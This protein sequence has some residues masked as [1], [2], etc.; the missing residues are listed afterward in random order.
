MT[1]VFCH[2]RSRE[3]RV[4]TDTL[5]IAFDEDGDLLDGMPI[6]YSRA[7]AIVRAHRVSMWE[8][9]VTLA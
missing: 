5:L 1:V 3:V 9:L 6:S 8:E 2:R 7:L 4:V